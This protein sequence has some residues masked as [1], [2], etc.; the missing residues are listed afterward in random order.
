[1][2]RTDIVI[3]GAG[4]V[5]LAIARSLSGKG[6]NIVHFDKH[7]S[8]G[9]EA[10]SRCSEVIHA[11]I[12][13]PKNSLK[14][15]LCLEGNDLIYELCRKYN[16]PY[17][18]SGK[19]I[20]ACEKS[21]AEKLP[22]WFDLAKG[23]NAKGVRIIDKDEI[24]KIEPKVKAEAAIYCPSSGTV[25]SHLL[26]QL[27]EALAVGGGVNIV[28]NMEIT[29]IKK[30]DSGYIVD[31][32]DKSGSVNKLF[33]RILINAAGL[34]SDKIASMAGIDIDEAGYRIRYYKGIYYRANK[35]LDKYPETLIYP[36]PPQWG[37][38]GIHTTPDLG[39]GMRL[40]PHFIWCD[41]I[42][43]SIDDRFHDMFYHD[44]KRYLPFLEY[45][46]ILPDSSGIMATIMD[47]KK[48]GFKDFI[49]REESDKNLP[50]L[51]NLIGIDSPG[52]TA[53]PAIG[54][55]VADI[56]NTIS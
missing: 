16:V 9:R 38:V 52:L 33:T 53:S 39:G 3:I 49:I 40:G 10:S 26:M 5:G 48:P 18:N 24:F 7:A 35:Q 47:P 2:E 54:A 29:S 1:M 27:F 31:V 51:I 41:E 55:M 42:D 32:N 12:Y 28:Y 8:F 6:L 20:V 13:Y 50:G 19:L 25:D 21:E 36:I 22:F 34:G 45:D 4:I 44:A 11:G 14:G 37:S 56:V 46:D 30:T 17:K 43:Y 15:K 23:N